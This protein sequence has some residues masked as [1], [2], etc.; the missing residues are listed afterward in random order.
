M[1]PQAVFNFDG[2]RVFEPLPAA[3]AHPLLEW[4]MN[5]CAS[6]HAHQYLV[7]HAASV[8]RNGHALVLPAPSGS[9]KSTLCAALVQSGW[10]LLTDELTLV[11]LRDGRLWPLCRPV[12]LKNRSVAVIQGLAPSAVFNRITEDTI[13][14]SVTHMR[15]EPEHL[16]RIDE[17]AR[18]RWI[19]YPR[20]EAGAPTR[21]TPR[22]RTG[23]VVDL[24]RQSFNFSVLGEPGFAALTG[25]VGACTCHDFSYSRLP[26]ALALFNAMAD[27]PVAV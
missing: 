5:W 20:Y 2:R 10:R 11:D 4:A 16:R 24:A 22:A 21:L 19:V 23:A 26:E 1:R 17:L 27:T 14:G 8:E 25:L 13:K 12:S 18:A 6:S 15:V 7:I 9:G 3:H